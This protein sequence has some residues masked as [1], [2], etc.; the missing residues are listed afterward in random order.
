[1]G[2][3]FT[4]TDVSAKQRRNFWSLLQGQ[5][6]CSTPMSELPQDLPPACTHSASSHSTNT[7]F[8]TV[9]PGDSPQPT[10][11]QAPASPP[12]QPQDSGPDTAA[13]P[14]TPSSQPAKASGH[15]Q[16]TQGMLPHKTT[17]SK[18]GEIAVSPHSPRSQNQKSNKI[19]RQR[20]TF[21]K[22]SETEISN[23]HGKEFKKQS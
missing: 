18:L 3:P 16:L 21:Q 17:P 15:K 14:L 7:A 5:R 9:L 23:L 12:T 22:P 4:N 1:M 6:H 8:S 10:P 19:R 20:N 13:S 2:N 11:T